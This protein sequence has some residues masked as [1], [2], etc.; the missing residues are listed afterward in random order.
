MLYTNPGSGIATMAL[1]FA[2][3]AVIALIM[4]GS[5]HIAL[6]LIGLQNAYPYLISTAESLLFDHNPARF[7]MSQ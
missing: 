5:L 6:V 7:A 3:H 2:W 1:G 4:L